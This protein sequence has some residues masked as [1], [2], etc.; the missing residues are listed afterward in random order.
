MNINIVWIKIHIPI[1]SEHI[2]IIRMTVN[3]WINNEDILSI[4]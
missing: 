3:I 4:Q 1:N 2:N